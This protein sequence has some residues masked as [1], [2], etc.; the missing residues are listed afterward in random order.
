[1]FDPR[2]PAKGGQSRQ[3]VRATEQV[4]AWF[5]SPRSVAHRQQEALASRLTLVSA[6]W[7]ISADFPDHFAA[8]PEICMSRRIV[9]LTDG[10]T[11]P[12][13]AKTASCMIRYSNDDIV[14]LFDR[15]QVGQT[16]QSLLDVGGE[17]PVIGALA[18]APNAD[19]LVL[20]IAPPGGKIP[21]A[22]REVIL[23]AISRRMDVI[24]GLHEFLTEDDEFVA[25]ASRHGTNLHDVRKNEERDIALRK[26]LRPDCLRVLTVGNDCSVG[27]MLTSVE[28]TKGLQAVGK[29]AHF[30]ATGQTGIMV[31]GEGCPID[32][33]IADFVSGAVEK[34]IL[35]HQHHEILVV[36]GQGSLVHPSYSAVTLGLLHGA[37]PQ[38]LIL[39]YEVGRKTITG[40]ERL[41]IPPLS[42]IKDLNET[43][44]SIFMP[45]PVIGIAMN[46]RKVS[47]DE[48]DDERQRI[49]DKFE[50]PVCD[51]IRHGRKE[52]VEAV[53]AFRESNDWQGP[54]QASRHDCD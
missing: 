8:N 27:K 18:D 47:R 49:R 4:R 5:H 32:R 50:L 40:L 11:E 2:F 28:L 26:N 19:T 31:A 53:V 9:I 21:P 33:V 38:A 45:C 48:A 22:W 6:A 20:G 30:I 54:D 39:C 34:M 35:E 13:R 1:M 43:M 46:S 7:I 42:K 29:D 15:S 52:L 23:E 37:L 25:A 10:Y 16:S 17:I 41:N 12:H 3:G 51:V 14:A 36:E 44:A 24:G